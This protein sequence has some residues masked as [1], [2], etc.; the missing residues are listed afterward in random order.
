MKDACLYNTYYERFPAFKVA[1]EACLAETQG[2]HRAALDRLPT[3]N[4]QTFANLNQ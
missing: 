3:L 4:F 2:R 1:I